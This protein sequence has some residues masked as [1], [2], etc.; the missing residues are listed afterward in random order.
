M[1]FWD[2][3]QLGISTYGRGRGELKTLCPK[4]SGERKNKTDKCLSVNLDSGVYNCHH[5]GWSGKAQR[6][7]EKAMHWEKPKK[8]YAKPSYQPSP[9]P[10]GDKLVEW[11]AKRGIPVDV[12]Q[13][14]Q[15][16]SR[17]AWMPQTNKDERVIAFP[18]FRDGEVVN[19][20][21]RTVDKQFRMEKNAETCLYGLD[22]IG[23]A[24]DLIFVEGEID[25]LSLET[26]GFENCVSVPNGADSDLDCLGADS[27]RLAHVKRFILAVDNDEKGEKLKQKLISRIGRDRCWI[28]EWPFPCKD[29]N[30]VLVEHGADKLRQ[31]VENAKPIPIEGA[32]EI[33]DLRDEVFALYEHGT[34]NG[35]HPGWDCL[36]DL[37]R[38]VLGQW[39]AVIAIPGSGKTA[40]MA[41]LMVNL[42]REQDWKFAVFPAENLPAAE[43]AS[44]L[45]EIYLGAPF[46]DGPTPR[47]SREDLGAALD[48]LQEHFVILSPNDDELDL[49]SLLSMAKAYCLR[50]GINGFVIDPW[51]ELDH[52]QPANQ[53]ETQY[54]S[55]S[56]IKVRRFAKSHNI[57]VWIVVH[58]TKLAKDREGRYPVPTLYDAAGSAHWRNKA[59]FG[60]AIYRH[61]DDHT[62]PTEIHVQ[63]VRWKWAG[64][65][66][67][68]YLY[69]DKVCGRY[70][71]TRL[72]APLPSEDASEDQWNGYFETLPQRGRQWQ[73]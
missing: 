57:H 18:Y 53:T 69:F 24:D 48:W 51:N 63:K 40:W 28:V 55:H 5:C 43:Y 47:M 21:Y 16:E 65:L 41:A 66:G 30:E 4:C 1:T 22:D 56:L 33:D 36:N 46:N 3:S 50:R 38:P 37:Y 26:V 34:P 62:K 20:K 54:V 12:I 23:D 19:V 44:M 31:C 49:D 29:A 39:T 17:S 8:T 27:E 32:F 25:K 60:I 64:K 67:L 7:G 6:I 59:D 68:A 52:K 58:P 42:A 14:N 71:E 70:S 73:Q 35:A 9:E 72:Y 11:F 10:Q 15:I 2:W 45:A 13:R 61:F